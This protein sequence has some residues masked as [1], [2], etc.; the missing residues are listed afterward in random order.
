MARA[1]ASAATFGAPIAEGL[2]QLAK[3]SFD[4]KQR[5]DTT[6]AEEAAVQFEREKNKLFY[7]PDKGY[8]NTQGKT[9]YDQSMQAKKSLEELKKQFG[10]NLNPEAKRMFNRV[11]DQ[12]ITK[13][14][15]S[16]AQHASKGM[17]AWEVA[18]IESQ[19]ENTIE[20]SS[21]YWQNP[22]ELEV[23]R[24]LGRQAIMDS[25]QLQGLTD[26]AI[27]NEKLQTFDSSFA[28]ST[29]AAATNSSAEE[30]QALYDKYVKRLEGP[31]R[32]KM[33]K[34]IASKVKEEKTQTDAAFVMG[35]ANKLVDQYDN[36]D[37]I[38]NEVNKIEDPE[39][40]KKVQSEVNTQFNIKK[41]GEKER[42]ANHYSDAIDMVNGG[43]SATQ[44][45]AQHPKV[46]E[47]M[48]P[49]QRNNILAGKHMTTDQ[50]KF[51][52]VMTLPR[53]ELA[54]VNPN[55][56][57]DVFRK[58][59]MDKLRTAVNKAK[60]G[61]TYT[62]I[63][64]PNKK[65]TTVAERFFGKQKSWQSN[66]EKGAKVQEFMNEVQGRIEEAESDKGA[67][68]TPVELDGIV[69]EYSR[70]YVIER[71]FMGFDWLSPDLKLNIKEAP[72]KQ[73]RELNQFVE[74]YG[75][76]TLQDI[77]NKLEENNKPVNMET[78]LQVINQG[79][80]E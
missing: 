28:S 19:V 60:Q 70:E 11:A 40:R 80:A 75:E 79:T 63:T 55:D 2:S 24:A 64:S 5:I 32:V 9:A 50:I 65:V 42:Q 17:K 13:G 73:I 27:V 38:M 21:L 20:N 45:Q 78:I 76:N 61:Q 62:S 3:T 15:V 23:Q 29:I 67:K 22:K 59:D 69:N 72:P 10:D 46:W 52:A 41:N 4:I 49:G 18:T 1:S 56:Y 57:V 68:L 26:P 53:K 36:R 39:L 14:N 58:Q 43:M 31:D 34:L 44:I 30:G 37:D 66:K 12:H 48:S 35:T 54:Q 51:N 71:K 8:F 6:A 7:D 77:A 74:K 47:G 25:M 16:I 33:E